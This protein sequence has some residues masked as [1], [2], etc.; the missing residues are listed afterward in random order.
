M[1]N[2]YWDCFFSPSG[3]DGAARLHCPLCLPGGVC[4]PNYHQDTLLLRRT[5]LSQFPAKAPYPLLDKVP[6]TTLWRGPIPYCPFLYPWLSWLSEKLPV[7]PHTRVK[8]PLV[9][10]W[11]CRVGWVLHLDLHSCLS[12]QLER[13]GIKWSVGCISKSCSLDIWK[14]RS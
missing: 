2:L 7:R 5:G 13:R 6:I 9:F 1:W 11:C 4:W 12:L 14:K 10:N 3:C 8:S